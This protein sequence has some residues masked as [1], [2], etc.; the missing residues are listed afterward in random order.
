MV[1][2]TNSQ[3][4]SLSTSG[5]R[6]QKTISRKKR[7]VC[8]AA[9]TSFFRLSFAWRL[10]LVVITAAHCLV[11]EHG[12]ITYI[13]NNS[14]SEVKNQVLACL[15]RHTSGVRRLPSWV[16]FSSEAMAFHAHRRRCT[17]VHVICSC[18]FPCAC[19]HICHIILLVVPCPAG[20]VGDLIWPDP[21]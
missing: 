18:V 4:C 1:E 6:A 8:P 11:D 15:D 7:R 3:C 13:C 10:R 16:D 17:G 20:T 19:R 9:A 21:T 5:G 2:W 12:R 14:I